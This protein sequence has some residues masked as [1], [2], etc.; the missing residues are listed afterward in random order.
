MMFDRLAKFRKE[1]A[2]AIE[3][4]VEEQERS[5]ISSRYRSSFIKGTSS[6]LALEMGSRAFAGHI[7]PSFLKWKRSA[8]RRL[9][10]LGP[11]SK[12]HRF[13]DLGS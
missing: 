13:R 4:D 3:A 9:K 1:G 6:I 10:R 8:R 7:R 11:D 2:I 12:S 5:A